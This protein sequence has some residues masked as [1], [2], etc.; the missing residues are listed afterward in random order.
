MHTISKIRP[1]IIEA[2]DFPKNS[3]K[4]NCIS[5]KQ[6]VWSTH[7]IAHIVVQQ[8][9]YKTVFPPNTINLNIREFNEKPIEKKKCNIS[10]L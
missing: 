1:T 10:M 5:T 8:K 2:L 7:C 9:K 6:K 4:H 3:T